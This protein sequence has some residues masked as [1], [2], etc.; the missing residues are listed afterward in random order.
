[1]IQIAGF[2]DWP[3]ASIDAN[4]KALAI[5]LRDPNIAIMDQSNVGLVTVQAH[6]GTTGPE[7]DAEIDIKLGPC[8]TM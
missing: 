3:L 4:S 8:Q 5:G 2:I 1:M 7:E 6:L